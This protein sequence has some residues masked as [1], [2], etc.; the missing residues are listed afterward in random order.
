MSGFGR[1]NVR[2]RCS[3]VQFFFRNSI[4]NSHEECPNDAPKTHLPMK[5]FGPNM[6]CSILRLGEWVNGQNGGECSNNSIIDLQVLHTDE[7]WKQ[8]RRICLGS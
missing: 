6:L 1:V 8:R 3:I 2:A 7:L 4:K 5:I